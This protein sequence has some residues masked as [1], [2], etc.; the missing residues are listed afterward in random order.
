MYKM[1]F[2]V[3][4][5]LNENDFYQQSATGRSLSLYKYPFVQVRLFPENTIGLPKIYN[6]AIE[7]SK[8][9]PCVLIFCHDDLHLT[10]YFMCDQIL[11][12]L[13]KFQILGVAGN[14]RRAPNQPAWCHL[15]CRFIGD[16]PENL[17][18]IV[19]HG[20]G[21]PPQILSTFG[22]TCQKV[23]LLDG[24]FLAAFSKTLIKYNLRF[25][26]RFD[27]H[28]YDLDF[29][30]QA[31]AAGVIC[32]TWS[33]SLIHESGGNPYTDGWRKSYEQ[34]IQKWGD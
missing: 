8:S 27:F 20:N 11:A 2:V 21:F 14:K 6:I 29:C 32:G 28:F 19:G 26:E 1:K 3:A 15:D 31:E 18:G 4:T 23:K 10:D 30:R 9:D 25:D 22:P 12:G 5:R 34:Y 16:R 7:E 13:K 24:L 17:S 33:L